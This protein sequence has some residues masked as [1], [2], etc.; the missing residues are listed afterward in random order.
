MLGKRRYVTVSALILAV[1][2]TPLLIG[3]RPAQAQTETVLYNFTGG[4]DGGSPAYR[5][6]SDG[7]GNFYGTTF[8]G[9]VGDEGVGYGTV[10][11][12]SPN[13]GEGWK[14]TVLHSFKGGADGSNPSSYVIFDSA[15]NLYGTTGSGGEKGNGVVFELSPE[16][17][18]WK[19]TVLYRFTGTD[20]ANPA[21]GL[22][23]DPV[24][25][26][27]GTTQN[28]P[29]GNPIVFE[30]SPSGGAWTEQ[31]IYTIVNPLLVGLPNGLTMDAA[32]NIF[33]TTNFTVFE[34]SPNGNDGWNPN[35]LYTFTG[36]PKDGAY[37][38]GTLV[39]DQA[40]NLYGTTEFGGAHGEK[41]GGYGT[42][43]KLTHGKKGWKE[44]ILYSFKGGRQ[45]GTGPVAGIVFDASG[46]I[47]GTTYEGGES[48]LGTVFEL[49]APAGAGKYD[50]KVLWS[51]NGPDGSEPFASLILDAAGNLY[52]STL[53]G[54]TTDQG[55]SS[56]NGVVFEVTP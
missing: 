49:V 41:F 11:E 31:V 33:G 55:G 20:G 37:A 27:Y 3:A 50:E 12:L 9:G 29:G 43:Y 7:A 22:I 14:E 32:G 2:S 45:D 8:E 51:F 53:V 44:R 18:K 13:G 39:L 34:L 48:G 17:K 54:G 46:N 1:L 52:G 36:G 6:T 24:G 47:C 10:F 5:L 23:F 40:G 19:E 15:G 21:N 56:G 30:L 4:S 28:G 42:V 26:L 25:N 16:G 38:L 35:V